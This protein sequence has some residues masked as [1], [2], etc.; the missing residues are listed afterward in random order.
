MP[1]G[2]PSKKTS[3]ES[4]YS[5]SFALV[6]YMLEIWIANFDLLLL[7]TFSL[8]VARWLVVSVGVVS[9]LEHTSLVL[10]LGTR[11]ILGKHEPGMYSYI[12][13]VNGY[14]G[15]YYPVL[16][17]LILPQSVLGW[18]WLVLLHVCHT[19]VVGSLRA[20]PPT[21]SM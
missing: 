19:R 8:H 18:Y 13:N 17:C 4:S 7:W 16:T 14:K 9:T 11:L 10:V 2:P 6:V 5:R 12:L 3:T 1:V 21:F 15:W 20:S